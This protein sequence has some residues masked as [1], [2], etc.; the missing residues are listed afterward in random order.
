MWSAIYVVAGVG[1]LAWIVG[2]IVDQVRGRRP[3]SG[4]LAV[5]VGLFLAAAVLR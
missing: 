3:L 5:L 4:G 1:A 2:A